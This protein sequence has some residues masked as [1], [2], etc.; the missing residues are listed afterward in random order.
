MQLTFCF[1]HCMTPDCT[2]HLCITAVQYN[3]KLY[4][5]NLLSSNK[6]CH[7]NSLNNV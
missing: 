5:F 6:D 3:S 7:F 2:E 4:V 1:I